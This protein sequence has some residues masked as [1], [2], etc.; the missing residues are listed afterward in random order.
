MS[1]QFQIVINGP[2]KSGVYDFEIFQRGELRLWDLSLADL[3][4][5]EFEIQ[6]VKVAIQ[7]GHATVTTNG[8]T[9]TQKSNSHASEPQA[10]STEPSTLAYEFRRPWS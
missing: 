7:C 3:M 6:R 1:S 8:S 10:S 4:C 2:T 5:L 9:E